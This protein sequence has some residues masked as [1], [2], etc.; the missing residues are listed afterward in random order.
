MNQKKFSN[1]L[2]SLLVKFYFFIPLF[3][4]IT[5]TLSS[6]NG[7][8]NNTS[9]SDTMDYKQYRGKTN[10]PDFPA[11][12][13]WLNT[14]KN[15]SVKD[16]KG[17]IVLLDFWT[18]CCI[19]CMHILPDLHKL[20][21]KY[22]ELVIV[23]VH[24]AKFDNEKGTDNIKQAIL[25]Y[26]IE[27]PVIVDQDFKIWNEYTADSWPT[28]ILIDPDGKVVGKTSG[29]G[30]FSQLDPVIADM[31]KDFSEQGKLNHE[32]FP[33]KLVK[34]F[35]PE[36]VLSFPGKIEADETN[37]RL[38]I[39][40]SNHNRVLV[41]D[42]KGMIQQVI[43]SGE[44]GTA[45]GDFSVA[46]FF[47][48]QGLC[49]DAKTD[50]LYVADTDNHLVRKVDLKN[51][52]VTTILGTGTQSVYYSKEAS[53]TKEAIN[54]PWDV[55]LLNGDLYIAMAGPHQIW[56]M[57]LQT[58]HAEVYA[59]SGYENI[60]DGPLFKAALAQPSG[61]CTDGKILYWVDSETSSIR[62]A[63]NGEVKTLIGE[64]LFEFGDKD[65]T[66]PDARLQHPIGIAFHNNCL[67]IADTYNNKIKK[68]DLATKKLSS[69]AGTGDEGYADKTF[70]S[71]LFYEPNDLIW[72]NGLLY[73]VD[74][75]NHLIRIMNNSTGNVSTLN[76][77]NMELLQSKNVMTND[78]LKLIGQ[79]IQ[80]PTQ[81]LKSGT[82]KIE[83][84]LQLPVDYTWNAEAPSYFEI[85]SDGKLVSESDS[86]QIKQNIL[87]LSLIV[88][89]PS[90]TH[91]LIVNAGVYYCQ[92]G[93]LE[94]CYIKNL[95]WNFPIHINDSGATSITINQKLDVE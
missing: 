73:I 74:T 34:Q 75:N 6:C 43:G 59:G 88:N 38:F 77:S 67:Y 54:S 65:G 25:R 33:F 90:V 87:T 46:T 35:A 49:Y 3:V 85:Y 40:D 9:S 12:F 70:N 69:I 32:R 62:Y 13:Q 44:R 57:N 58:N 56:K 78:T 50:V 17:K 27:H 20:E 15:Y 39:T 31:V 36:G 24:S 66:Y 30:V 5:A 22:P 84:S 19:N 48:P 52:T 93:K 81:D 61:I 18:Y 7:Q 83:I 89:L 53:G 11:D 68:F 55:V 86:I 51:K 72:F 94:Q 63:E 16:F 76:L 95:N 28:F 82:N 47:R 8:S 71:S 92:H 2:H 29:E 41:M 4:F 79:K 91:N 26:D 42:E 23:G 80:M 14:D 21:L 45:D 1:R 60:S 10:A 37:N 64:G